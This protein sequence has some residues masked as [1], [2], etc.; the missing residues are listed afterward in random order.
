[1]HYLYW[2]I[3]I[4]LLIALVI[5][6]VIVIHNKRIQKR[7][8]DILHLFQSACEEKGILEYT[9]EHVKKDTHDFYFEDEKNIYYIKVIY[10]LSNQEIC[11]N[12]AIKWQL[13]KFG[14]P[15][16]KNQFVDEVEPLMRLDLNHPTKKEHKLFIVY[17]DATAL[18]KVINECEMEFVYPDTDVYGACVIP[19]AK[20]V[21][22]LNLL[23]L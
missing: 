12:N 6:G 20:L 17:P 15:N 4:I 19:Y 1:M 11:I 9:L 14:E 10:N 5:F 13:R 21:E 7:K 23:E 16:Q 22:N 18:L 3:G 8:N 2:S